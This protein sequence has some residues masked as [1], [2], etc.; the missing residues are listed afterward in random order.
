MPNS[1]CAREEE[2]KAFAIGDLPSREVAR[3]AAHFESCPDC[4]RRLEAAE[5]QDDPLLVSLRAGETVA[6]IRPVSQ[7]VPLHSTVS[8]HPRLSGATSR[9]RDAVRELLHL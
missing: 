2:L 6:P 1:Q 7:S 8:L 4:Q 9:L 5:Q 3:L